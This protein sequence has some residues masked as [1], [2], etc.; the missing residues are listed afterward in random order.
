MSVYVRVVLVIHCVPCAPTG[1]SELCQD[2]QLQLVKQ[3]TFEVMMAR[4]CMLID[5][6]KETMLDPSHTIVCPRSVSG[7]VCVSCCTCMCSVVV[8]SAHRQKETYSE[9]STLSLTHIHARA[10]AHTYIHTHPLPR[11]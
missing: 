3:G 11:H 8:I 6:E 1:F 4:F 5:H 10:Q 7:R 2:D 9:T